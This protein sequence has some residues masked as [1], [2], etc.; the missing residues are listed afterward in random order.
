MSDTD[1]S[2]E[3]LGRKLK[4][5]EDNL[6]VDEQHSNSL[7]SWKS[8]PSAFRIFIAALEFSVNCIFPQEILKER[9]E[10]EF[11][12]NKMRGERQCHSTA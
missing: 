3:C 12:L 9:E 6:P 5:A 10:K 4:I 1:M 2:D 7:Q 11:L 8:N